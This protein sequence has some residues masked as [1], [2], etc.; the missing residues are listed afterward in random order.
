MM[1]PGFL[2][3][4]GKSYKKRSCLCKPLLLLGYAFSIQPVSLLDDLNNNLWVVVYLNTRAVIHIYTA[5]QDFFVS[6]TL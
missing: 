5:L 4:V 1:Q 2:L 3:L 6:D